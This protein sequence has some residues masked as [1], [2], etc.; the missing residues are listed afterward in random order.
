LELSKKYCWIKPIRLQKNSGPVVAR[1]IAI[2][3]ARGKYLSFIDVDDYWLPEKLSIHIGFMEKNYAAIS[4]SDCRYISEDGKL[5]GRR[6]SGVNK[7]GIHMHFMTRYIGCLTVIVNRHICEDF[8]F[9]DIHPSVRAEDF[10]AWLQVIRAHG[11]AIRCPHDL[12]RYS[13]VMNS[14]SSDPIQASL[15][16]WKLYRYSLNLPIISA[17]V[18]FG[19]YAIFVIYKRFYFKP[20]F[21]SLEVDSNLSLG[22]TI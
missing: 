15:S 12:A 17:G 21:K 2:S 11:P 1:N 4:F 9:P 18:Y 16:V 19:F 5:I 10:L 13:V 22:Y 20:R 6:F 7:V 14:R 3:N 8:Y